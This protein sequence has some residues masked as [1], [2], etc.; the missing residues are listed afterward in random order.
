MSTYVMTSLGGSTQSLEP[1]AVDAF[2][3]QLK[4]ELI[5]PSSRGYDEARKIW[6]AMIDRRP[7]LIARCANSDD[8]VHAVRFAGQHGLLVSVRGGGHN[9]A[10]NAVCDGGL[11]IDL[12]AMKSVRVDPERK[13]VRVEPGVTLGEMDRETQAF[14]LATPSGI[15]STTGIAGLTLG[16]GFGWISR[17]YGMTID[18]LIEAEVVTARGEKLRVSESSNPDLFWG[19]RGG[20][21]NFGVVTSFEF[22]LHPVGPEVLAGLVVHPIADAPS[23][24]RQ[25]RDIA[26]KAPDEF[27]AWVV[28]RKAPPLPFLPEK[29]HGTDILVFAMCYAGSIADGER[30]AK[31]LRSL[32]KPIADVVGPSP[33]AGFQ[34]AFDPLLTPGLRNYWKSHNFTTLSD[35]AIDTILKHVG[36]LPT[37]LSEAFIGQMGGAQSR[38][39]PDATAYEHRQIAFILNVHTRWENASDDR[40]CITWARGFFDAMRPHATGGVYVNFMPDDEGDRVQAAYGR[41]YARL[42][43]LK[44]K[45]DPDNLFRLN[46]N[47]QPGA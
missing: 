29:V 21:G 20:G 47:I 22:R 32:G 4:G 46:Q 37:P 16:G 2:G 18:N 38:V 19:I 15:N 1:G 45:Y 28:L 34:S 35:G 43:S 14:G 7:G 31:P 44:K 39:G 11:V 36:S 8:V 25:Y 3:K 23:L 12:S 40:R 27:T 10:G 30:A 9:I 41:N 24:L 33:F 26:A 13:T 17:K 5:T 6:N 42:A